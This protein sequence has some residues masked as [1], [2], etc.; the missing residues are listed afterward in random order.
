MPFVDRFFPSILPRVNHTNNVEPLPEELVQPSACLH[1][2]HLFRPTFV[3][4]INCPSQLLDIPFV[5]RFF[6]SILI[7]AC[8]WIQERKTQ[9]RIVPF[10][11]GHYSSVNP[12]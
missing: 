2:S 8:C 7:T 6:P 5:D 3:D 1:S 4:Y 11:D 9:A 10:E 12:Q